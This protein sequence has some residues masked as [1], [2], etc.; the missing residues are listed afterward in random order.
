VSHA[1]RSLVIPAKAQA[2]WDVLADFGTISAWAD[3]IDHSCVLNARPDVIGTTRRIQVGRN[4]V[5]ERITEF[6]PP[7]ALAYAIEG[8][9]PRLGAVSNRWTLEPQGDRT[10]VTITSSVHTGSGPLARLT[11]TVA[12]RVLARQSDGMLAGLARTMGA[13]T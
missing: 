1:S 4:T 11:E 10:R 6:D 13:R 5:V 3:G 12:A 7:R 8:L 9:P 2:I